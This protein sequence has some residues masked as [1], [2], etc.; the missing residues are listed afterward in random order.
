[1]EHSGVGAFFVVLTS[2]APGLAGVA[3]TS[4]TSLTMLLN[5]L[6]RM[7][8]Q[9]EQDAVSIERISQYNE[10]EQEAEFVIQ[11]KTPPKEWP[12]NGEIVMKN[13]HMKYRKELDLVL[14]GMTCTVV[15]G[16]K[17][18]VIGRTGAGKS[19]L[20]VTLL[21]ICEYEGGSIEI[22]GVDV[23]SIGLYDL[24][25]KISVIPQDP[26]LFIGTV[27]RNLDPFSTATDEQ[28]IE[29]LK[30]SH[31]YDG[32]R[33]MAIEADIKREI[34]EAREAKRKKRAERR[35][36]K[37][38]EAEN[39]TD[40]DDENSRESSVSSFSATASSVHAMDFIDD[41]KYKDIN[42]LD[43][44]VVENGA[45][46]SVGQ[47]QLL[48]LARAVIRKSKILLLDEA[49]SAVDHHTDQLIQET[50]RSVFDDN[51]I[52]TIAHRID[53]VLD[54]DKILIMDQGKILEYDSPNNLLNNPDSK[55]RSIVTESFGVDVEDVIQQKSYLSSLKPDNLEAGVSEEPEV[56]PEPNGPPAEKQQEAGKAEEEEEDIAPDVPAGD[57]EQPSSA[58]EE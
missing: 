15:G 56:T 52:L 24:R 20:F 54:Y 41:P 37:A 46:F 31:C 43:I 49:T 58:N 48:C 36:R 21:R 51:T 16:E 19:S 27:R 11:H 57:E 44:E 25:S 14:K 9:L 6:V 40:G 13:V 45:N 26:V 47:R 29:A 38:A 32:L 28:L 34:R 50:I 7:K 55:F 33:K 23:K 53:T 8:A 18:G 39:K 35:A 1:M 30:L 2:A 10:I 22:D 42:P 17:V 4:V 5:F 3:L 12:Q